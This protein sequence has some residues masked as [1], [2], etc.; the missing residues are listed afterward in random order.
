MNLKNIFI[1]ICLLS[2]LLVSCEVDKND[3]KNE[4][5]EENPVL[6]QFN[7]SI[8][9]SRYLEKRKKDSSI[10]YV[11]VESWTYDSK[12][13]LS[14]YCQY[15]NENPNRIEVTIYDNDGEN[16]KQIGRQILEY[17]VN[18][19][20]NA[21]ELFKK[22][23]FDTAGKLQYT[24]A[25]T[26]NGNEIIYVEKK[27]G[28]VSECK[29]YVYDEKNRLIKE[30]AYSDEKFEDCEKDIF[31]EYTADGKIDTVITRNYHDIDNDKSDDVVK[32][33]YTKYDYNIAGGKM[34]RTETFLLEDEGNKI[35]S[36]NDISDSLIYDS[37]EIK[38][39]ELNDFGYI[40]KEHTI[41]DGKDQNY[42]IYSYGEYDGNKYKENA[43]LYSNTEVDN[44]LIGREEY[45]LYN[46]N[47]S[48]EYF[49]DESFYCDSEN[50]DYD[51]NDD[52]TYISRSGSRMLK[53]CAMRVNSF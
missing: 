22:E 49:Y 24:S 18:T 31:Y 14:E 7:N 3:K 6:E 34:Y 45:R 37:C 19:V 13:E 15:T 9:V 25:K 17:G 30:S 36:G 28:E 20:T 29:K 27:N 47:Q 32:T 44:Q 50:V 5:K 11:P 10:G 39:Y 42:T 48:A 21:R 51:E 40:V 41:S 26:V 33:Y 4:N 12:G 16:K 8:P 23:T 1:N 46:G 38:E 35:T 43:Y 53:G 2:I 52:Y